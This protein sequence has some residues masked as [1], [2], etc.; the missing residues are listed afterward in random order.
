MPYL[1]AA[2]PLPL[3]ADSS[4]TQYVVMER[5]P[6]ITPLFTLDKTK[7]TIFPN[8]AEL[9]NAIAIIKADIC[10]S[11]KYALSVVTLTEVRA[12]FHDGEVSATSYA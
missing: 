3:P 11:H 10:G 4:A 9:D 7:A 6:H 8:R 12:I 1:L 5:G 2:N